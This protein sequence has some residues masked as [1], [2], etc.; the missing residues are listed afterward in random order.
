MQTTY[1]DF[2]RWAAAAPQS[3]A[4]RHR[5]ASLTYA[6]LNVRANQ[7][8]LFLQQKGLVKGQPVAVCLPPGFTISIALLAIHKI[9]CIY[10]PLDPDYP[11]A[12]LETILAEVIP[13]L[14]LTTALVSERLPHS[15]A[16]LL[17]DQVAVALTQLPAE[18]L[19]VPVAPEDTAYIYF[20]SGTTGKPKGV[21]ASHANLLHYV[22]TARNH[23]R[24]TPGDTMPAVARFTFSISMF[25]LMLPLTSGGTLQLLDRE[26]ILD[27]PAMAASLQEVTFFHIGP[28]LLRSLVSYI[29]THYNDFSVF[30]GVRHASSGG[31][32]IPPELLE[33]LREIFSNAEV[34]VIYGCS[35]ISCMGCTYQAPA[36]GKIT[37]TYVGKPLKDVV[38]RLVDEQGKELPAGEIGEICFGGKGVVKGYLNRPELTAEKF[39]ATETDR[40]YATGD[41]GRFAADGNLEMLGRRDFQIQLRGMRIELAEVEFTLR[42]A[43]GVKD[44]VV[45]AKDVASGEKVLVAYCVFQP[46]S[47]PDIHAVKNFA[48]NQL[49]DYMVPTRYLV[50]EALPLNHN[51]KVD[52]FALPHPD[53]MRL[54][55]SVDNPPLTDTEKVIAAVWEKLLKI[56][57]IQRTDNFFDLGGYSLLGVECVLAAEAVLHVKIDGMDLLREN[58]AMLAALVDKQCGRETDSFTLQQPRYRIETFYFGQQERLYGTYRPA[59]QALAA[60]TI[61]PAIL[62]CPAFGSEWIRAHFVM[63]KVTQRLVELGYPVMRFDFS[64]VGDSLGDQSQT[65]LADW[66]QDLHSASEELRRRS[67]C[68]HIIGIGV[69]WGGSLLRKYGAACGIEQQILW[70]PIISGQYH[71]DKLRNSHAQLRKYNRAIFPWFYRP[72]ALKGEELLGFH[73]SAA[74]IE[75]LPTFSIE[76]QLSL[77]THVVDSLGYPDISAEWAQVQ[78]QQR[79]GTHMPLNASTDWW[80]PA[81]LETLWPDRGI[82]QAIVSKVVAL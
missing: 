14:T 79:L 69:R 2:E 43:P 23:Y 29:R 12:R 31:D 47:E 71:L 81:G 55:S 64:G 7:L 5:D 70:D 36:H 11:R 32:M 48:I 18:N 52:R 68:Q 63:R 9:G 78:Q 8:A 6:E 24:F 73:Y 22:N 16:T 62:I 38:L 53:E 28:S 54:I 17:L 42:R 76:E 60:S 46:G 51:M 37:K 57:K 49:P 1:R 39:V 50:L 25:E 30:A 58:L 80:M 33:D 35:E 56:D 20:T 10:V 67:G 26:H 75:A 3:I 19:A 66:E 41:I 61:K 21:M 77:D 27:L 44:A 74:V 65:S 34:Y 72:A 40:F 59:Q 15:D 13:A 82:S 45:M 4:L